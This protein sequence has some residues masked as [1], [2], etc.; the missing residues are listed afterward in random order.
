[1]CVHLCTEFVF[2][3]KNMHNYKLIHLHVEIVWP[4]RNSRQTSTRQA[5][6]LSQHNAV[7]AVTPKLA[8]TPHPRN[9]IIHTFARV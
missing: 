9:K 6:K 5:N 1:M 8:R 2:A 4:S 3:I 7:V